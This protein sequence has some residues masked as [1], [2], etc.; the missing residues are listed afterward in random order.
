VLEELDKSLS[1]LGD[2]LDSMT[3]EQILL[4]FTGWIESQY[5]KGYWTCRCDEDDFDFGNES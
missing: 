5:L 3:E 1:V 2:E 4:H